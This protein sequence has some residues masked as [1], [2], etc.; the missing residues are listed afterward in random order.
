MALALALGLSACSDDGGYQQRPMAAP[1]GGGIYGIN[2]PAPAA[3]VPEAAAPPP[4][5][6][7]STGSGSP[8]VAS[9]ESGVAVNPAVAAPETPPSVA[10]QQAALSSYTLGS[11]DKV[12]VTVYQEPDLSGEFEVGGNGRVALPLIGEVQALGITVPDLEDRIEAKLKGEG[13]LLEPR[14]NVE[15]LNYRPFFILG[16]VNKPGSYPYVNGMTVVNAAAMAEGFTYRAK[17]SS[18]EIVR[19]GAPFPIEANESSIVMPGDV[20]KVPERFF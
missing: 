18:I 3:P 5:A 19:D 14:V 8:A 9:A 13:Y 16:E 1:V 2:T 7:A 20:I 11:G 4:A 15:V 17:P 12:K 10:Q 6:P